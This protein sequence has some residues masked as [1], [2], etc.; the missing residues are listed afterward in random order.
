MESALDTGRLG[1]S[2]RLRT[3]VEEMPYERRSILDFMM[4]AARELPPGARVVD[5]GAGDSPYRELFA[6]TG[7][8]A[9]DWAQSPHEGAREV[10]IE[11]SAEAI[12]VADGAF[13]AAL[14]TQVLEHVPDPAA[15]VSE[16][17]RIVRP[18]GRLFVTVPLVWELHELPHDYFRYTPAGLG[19]LLESAG[20]EVLAIEPRNDCF[21]TLAQLLLNAGHVMGNAPDGLDGRRQA[22]CELLTELATE[23]AELAPLDTRHI[24]PLGYAATARRP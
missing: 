16:L 6:H 12:P 15:V 8:V 10:E 23:L 21:T 24:L 2:E 14:L 18:G 5:V 13:D 3:F 9:V 4:R 20:F 11:A 7:Y 19:H 17:H 22:A 1:L